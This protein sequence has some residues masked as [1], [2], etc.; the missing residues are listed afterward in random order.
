MRIAVLMTCYN[1][2]GM[3]LECLRHLFAATSIDGIIVDVWLNDDASPD[4]TGMKV[5]EAFPEIN[6]IQGSGHD[7]WC[8][9][10]RRI[11]HAA[12]SSGK[13]YDG[14]LWLND[15][16]MLFP[17]ALKDLI[18]ADDSVIVVGATQSKDGKDITYSGRDA[19]GQKI[20]P[21]GALQ[22]CHFM[23]GN[24]VFQKIGN[25][26]SYLTHGIGD[27]DYGLRAKKVG[28]DI[29]LAPNVV[30]ICDAKTVVEKWRRPDVPFGGRIKNLYSPLGGPEPH[31]FFR[32]NLA[33]FGIM[34]ALRVFVC[35][36]IEVCFPV[37]YR[38][39]KA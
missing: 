12:T 17:S 2:V 28:I 38:K 3:T 33:H 6:V 36:H 22:A 31:I 16:T 20:A 26:P 29:R 25:F 9:G 39:L 18:V 4:G 24:A 34:K 32:Y 8:G 15:D 21:N 14:Y 13:N 30:G 35:Q 23:N 1:R 27:Y 11:W 37:G 7:F 19:H 10:M 5:L